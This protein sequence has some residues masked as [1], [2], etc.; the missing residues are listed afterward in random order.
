MAERRQ[1]LG[2]SFAGAGVQT[3]NLGT[4]AAIGNAVQFSARLTVTRTDAAN[5]AED[6]A[7]FAPEGDG[8]RSVNGVGFATPIF[9][10]PTGYSDPALPPWTTIV[11]PVGWGFAVVFA[12]STLQL[13]W[14]VAAGQTAVSAGFAHSWYKNGAMT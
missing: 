5:E 12:G 7:Y 3:I 10:G 6:G 2:R 13:Q 11:V 14:N 1:D 8:A 4:V 9:V